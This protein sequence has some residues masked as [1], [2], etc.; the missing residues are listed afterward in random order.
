MDVMIFPSTYDGRSG[1]MDVSDVVTFYAE[2]A[3]LQAW[4]GVG[5]PLLWLRRHVP[6]PAGNETPACLTGVLH[7]LRRVLA[8]G[9]QQNAE[10]NARPSA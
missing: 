5:V 7:A 10:P 9:Q 2:Q 6:D 3:R 4:R 8:V 1:C